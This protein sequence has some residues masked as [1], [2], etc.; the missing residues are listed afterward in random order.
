ML[1]FKTDMQGAPIRSRV[2]IRTRVN[3]AFAL[4]VGVLLAI[5]AASYQSVT[6]LAETGQWIGHTHEVLAAIDAVAAATTTAES[7]HARLRAHRR[8]ALPRDLPVG[9]PRC[10]GLARR[11][12]A[13]D[14]GQ[15]RGAGGAWTGSSPSCASTW[16][17]GRHG[18]DPPRPER[19]GGGGAG[20]GR[21]QHRAR[22]VHPRGD[23][24][25]ARRRADAPGRARGRERQPRRPHAVDHR[26]RQPRGGRGH[27]RVEPAHLARDRAAARDRP[28]A[29]RLRG[30]LPAARRPQP[31]RDR[32]HPPGRRGA[33]AAT[34]PWSGSS[35][36][37]R[38]RKCSP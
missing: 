11:A 19:R 23:R 24:G 36:A 18:G 12:P 25:D 16:P 9:R 27:G 38:G 29:A 7:R 20:A 6:S 15:P 28:R 21:E 14:R 1:A 5:A 35:A 10:G 17:G 22:R 30:A 2:P 32:A 26:D 4:A 13:A 33:R 31:G 3:L 34:R 37:R 8:G